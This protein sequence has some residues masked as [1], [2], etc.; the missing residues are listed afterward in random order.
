MRYPAACHGRTTVLL[1]VC[2]AVCCGAVYGQQETDILTFM[3]KDSLHGRLISGSPDEYGIRW[4]HENVKN[5]IDFALL[6]ISRIKL[7][8]Q[9]AV[10]RTAF[11]ATVHLTNDDILTGNIVSLTDQSLVLDTWY[12]GK[13][14]IK[15]LM[16]KQINP[17]AGGGGVTYEG[18]ASITNW[19]T[20]DYNDGRGQQKSWKFKN[21][22]LYAAY[23]YPIARTINNMPS[24]AMIQFK[25]SWRGYPSFH[26]AFYSDNLQQYYGSNCYL[27]QVSSSSMSLQRYTRNSGSRSLGSVNYQRFSNQPPSQAVFTVLADKKKKSIV[28]LID[29]DMVKQWT[30]GDFFAGTGNAILFQ[31][32]SR[33]NLKISEIKVSE[34]D[35]EIPTKNAASR[36]LKQDLLRFTNNDKVSGTLSAIADGNVQ[37]KTTYATLTVPL[38]RVD[39]ITMST[40]N[41]ERA[42]RN[43]ND[44]RA[45]FREKG[46]ITVQM[47]K[48]Q[49]GKITGN[50]E[51]FGAATLP[52]EA[53]RSL[54]FN[55]Y[56]DKQEDDDG[57]D[58]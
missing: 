19:Q 9:Q 31:P 1:T 51:N 18:P 35:G 57:F 25:A 44:V 11:G 38:K 34:W 32:Q 22:A 33:G 6:G 42:R 48:L 43:R 58:F 3:N 23:T 12:A 56:E 13:M 30:D 37:F 53:F 7:S 21:N 15:R 24:T 41:A 29:G 40:Q 36:E 10:Q 28:L 27:L 17:N 5:P 20:R 8:K 49:D 14:G 54:E 39:Q 4:K 16:I 45:Q 55:V 50:S 2:I 47:T 26:F 52:I 46:S